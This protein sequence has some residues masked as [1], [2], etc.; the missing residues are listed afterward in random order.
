[1]IMATTCLKAL[2]RCCALCHMRASLMDV[3]YGTRWY[4]AA[5]CKSLTDD[6]LSRARPAWCPLME[7]EAG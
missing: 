1:M 7:V 3:G 2:P 5:T 4:C 6:Y